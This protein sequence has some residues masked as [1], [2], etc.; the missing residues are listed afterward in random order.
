MRAGTPSFLAFLACHA[1]PHARPAQALRLRFMD[2]LFAYAQVAFGLGFVI[3]V[4]ELGHFLVAKACGVRCDKFM[5]GFDIGGM[6]I[7]RQWGETFY[8]IGILPL[9]GYVKM[10]GQEDNVQEIAAELESS[11]ALEGSP[12]AKAVTGPDGNQVWIDKRSY[13]AKSVPQRMA[14]ISAGVIMN[15]IFA[16]FMA[17]AAFGVGVPVTPAT[18]GSTVAGGAAWKAGL[19]TGDR[20]VQIND[21][22]DPSYDDL[23]KAVILGDMEKGVQC[24]I[25]SA[26]GSTRELTLQ[27]EMQELAPMVGVSPT[28]RL[29]VAAKDAVRPGT[30]AAAAG[31][32][33]FRDGDQIVEVD[34]TPITTY[35]ELRSQLQAKKSQ[36]ISYTVVRGGKAP[37][38]N[39]FGEVTGGERTT[40]EI[41]PNPMERLGVVATLGP[42]TAVETGSPAEA[43][44]L[45]AG[46]QLLAVDGVVIGAAPNGE[47]A[48]DPILLEDRL[49]ASASR[50]ES[51]VLTVAGTEGTRDL[52]IA[53]RA[54]AW[55]STPDPTGDAP[56]ALDSIGVAVVVEAK[57]AA[58]VA[59]SPASAVDLRPGDRI[60]SAT[61]RSTVETDAKLNSPLEFG[62]G[63]RN[64]PLMVLLIQDA[65]PEF[66][67][68]LTV[69]RA[70]GVSEEG[71][72]ST[73]KVVLKPESSTEAF[74]PN[75]GVK[76]EPYK[77]L[78]TAE[79]FGE[80]TSL[81]YTEVK[82]QLMS[83]V[84]FLQKIGGQV[85]VKA[86][87]GPLT[88]AQHAG[89]AAFEGV[90][91]LLMSLVM[92]SANLAVL[93][94]LPIPVLDGGHMVFLIYEGITGRP[95]NEKIMIA[96][97]TVGLFFLLGLMLFVF[98]LDISRML[99]IAM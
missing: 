82:N 10:F 77:T 3:F 11:K 5:V 26:D 29:Q 16:F 57:V 76:L 81:A 43:A 23:S 75:R 33:S 36:P 86:L 21:I 67:V 74:T 80:R 20:M 49:A 17:W 99:G 34:G 66:E 8:G 32:K 92:L 24:K 22:P 39:P 27:P 14:I 78:R 52:T 96:M 9:G 64:W 4:H 98:T 55:A 93:N 37:L 85:S 6:K 51:V 59:G 84:R 44:G 15:V 40:F 89:K 48:I 69:A 7:G 87:G 70:T 18:V 72:A 50:G 60:V 54:V 62:D 58:L 47:E 97:Q 42:V 90:G 79:S 63:D 73:H 28:S 56:L 88:I 31:D 25:E 65:S 13:L 41:A 2:S 83:V 61:T 12:D 45:V 38:G 71:S 35:A 91:A 46:D 68:E 53:P 19:R 1:N 95:P 94:F 30:P